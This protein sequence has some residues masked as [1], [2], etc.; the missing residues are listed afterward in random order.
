MRIVI[1]L[2]VPRAVALLGALALAAAAAQE[3]AETKAPLFRL[4]SAD[5]RP[6]RALA[7][8]LGGS[9][10][11]FEVPAGKHGELR[12]A[13][14]LAPRLAT[15]DGE[16]A[17]GAWL[18]AQ[19]LP[20]TWLA[21][22]GPAVDEFEHSFGSRFAAIAVQT[23]LDRERGKHLLHDLIGVARDAEHI[24]VAVRRGS[25]SGAD[26]TI[27][28]QLAPRPGT[29]LHRWTQLLVPGKR[30]VP[31]VARDGDF[32]QIG[33]D[34]AADRIAGLCDPFVPWIAELT[35]GSGDEAIADFRRSIASQD[36]RGSFAAGRAGIRMALGLGKAKTYAEVAFAPGNIERV[37]ATL[38]RQRIDA[39][40]TPDAL[41]YRGVRAMKSVVDGGRPLPLFG[42]E[43]SEMTGYLAVAGDFALSVAGAGADEAAIKALV[44]GALDGKLPRRALAAA[45]GSA[46]S[47][48]LLTVSMDLALLFAAMPESA[49]PRLG[50]DQPRSVRISL[51][52]TGTALELRIQLQ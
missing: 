40:Y 4:A 45:D 15:L 11:A 21:R 9:A 14:D 3:P 37:K 10:G 51:H 31:T 18:E 20:S 17:G 28:L 7:L 35:S 2:T 44:D 36:G 23:G 29:A 30:E 24:D 43:R 41:E 39:E 6:L 38:A 16:V 34:I 27:V 48:P 5:G 33:V 47:P 22:L 52:Q 12:V 13:D 50:D 46:Q 25:G 26:T 32:V 42:G 1:P 8:L 49:R 19:V